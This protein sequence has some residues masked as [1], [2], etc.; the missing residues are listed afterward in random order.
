MGRHPQ[1]RPA[2]EVGGIRRPSAT[3][4][5]DP[6]VTR[7]RTDPGPRRASQRRRSSHAVPCPGRAR[8]VPAPPLGPSPG[9]HGLGRPNLSTCSTRPAAATLAPGLESCPA[10]SRRLSALPGSRLA[11]ALGLADP[12]LAVSLG[13][14]PIRVMTDVVFY[15]KP[16][17]LSNARQKALLQA[18]GHRLTV[19]DLLA[20]P[21]TTERLRGL[22]RRP[23]GD[24]LVQP[25]GPEGEVGRGR[26][27]GPGR[28]MRHWP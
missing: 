12:V 18:L 28:A 22:L 9:P 21:W 11:A 6:C 27:G 13:R 24:E 10:A 26:A 17:C 3:A 8:R 1:R 15:E 16:G 20:E 2:R 23:A 4:A 5:V 7:A 19:R 14:G 25:H